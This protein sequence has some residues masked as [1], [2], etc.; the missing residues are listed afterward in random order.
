MTQVEAAEFRQNA[1]AW[2]DQ[3]QSNRG[4]VVI[5]DDG[6]PVAVLVDTASYERLR[7]MD[8]EF[9]EARREFA[10]VFADIPEAKGLAM[11]DRICAEER[12]K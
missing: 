10:A 1:G 12:G 8:A 4:S 7:K 9:N 11:I 2:L 5:S 6:Q 3:V